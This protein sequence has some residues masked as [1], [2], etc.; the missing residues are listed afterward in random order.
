MAA[1]DL[2]MG[3][4]CLGVVGG[5]GLHSNSAINNKLNTYSNEKERNSTKVIEIA[6]REIGVRETAYN[7]SPRISEYLVCVGFKK[8]APWCAAFCSWCFREAGL[9]QPRTAWSP[10]LFPASRVRKEAAPGLILGIYFPS[11]GR[12]AHVGLVERV[13]GSL[14]FSIEGNTNVAGS[15]EGDG[16]LRKARHYRSIAS[17]AD[18]L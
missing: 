3:I 7:S 5:H 17:Y 4:V 13:Q 9:A 8:A 6:R 15:R 2:F 14:V 1:I 16:V 12:I 18:W 11:M 10:G